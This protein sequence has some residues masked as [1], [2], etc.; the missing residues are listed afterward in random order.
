MKELDSKKL[1]IVSFSI[2][3]PAN[4]GGVIDVF[5]KIKALFEAGV[6]IYL[7]CFQYDRKEAAE[8]EKYCA[9]VFYYPRKMK[10]AHLLSFLPFIVSSRKSEKLIENLLE[11]KASVLY[12]GLHTCASIN[13]PRLKNYQKIIRSHNIE[14]EY[15]ENLA[16]VERKSMKRLYFKSE[17]KKL[18]RFEKVAMKA[19]TTILG[20]SK[21]D[22]DYLE[23]NYGKTHFVSAF[24]AFKE[25]D[26]PNETKPFAFYHGNL[27]VGENNQAALFL[28][29]EVF[30]KTKRKLIIA[31]NSPSLLLKTTCDEMDHVEL[32][33]DESSEE[34]DALLHSATVNVL[35]TFQATGIKLKLLAALYRG[36]H[37]LVNPE[38]VQGTG[39]EDLVIIAKSAEDFISNIEGVFETPTKIDVAHRVDALAEF[40]NQKALQNLLELI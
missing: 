37:C 22:C 29:N 39:L 26:I 1:H 10:G 21:K 34:I 25:V 7:H 4:Y 31:G 33:S 16:A 8:L 2:P 3:Y 19:A 15:Y 11:V 28:V 18:R 30:S 13:D 14:H 23:E 38:M 35:P 6:E 17:A 20:I 5:Y 36:N 12:E 24:H 32:L 40:S 27:A 9:K